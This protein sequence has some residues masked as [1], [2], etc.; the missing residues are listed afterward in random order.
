MSSQIPESL[1]RWVDDIVLEKNP[2]VDTNY[3]TDLPTHHRI[4]S[5]EVDEP[6]YK[7]VQEAKR[8]ARAGADSAK[9]TSAPPPPPLPGSLSE[10]EKKKRKTSESNSIAG[11]SG[12]DGPKFIRKHIFPHSQIAMDDASLCN[13]L[14]VLVWPGVRS[15]GGRL[16]LYQE[17]E[18]RFQEEVA[19]M[20]EELTRLQEREKK[21]MGQCAMAK[22]LKEKAEQNYVMLF[23]D[24]I[25]LQKQIELNREAYQDLEDPIAESSEETWR[26]FKEH[27][28]VIAPGL[29]LSLLHPDKIV[30]DG[31]IVSPPRPESDSEL[32]TRKQRLIE[33]PP[34]GEQQE[35]YLP[36]SSEAPTSVSEETAPTLL[37]P[38]ADPSSLPVGD[39]NPSN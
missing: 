22:G 19:W 20:K 35:G 39:S 23:A 34:R 24:N 11:E 14:Q 18:K 38:A 33:S 17:E 28:G 2:L 30:I 29:D 37:T 4:C 5:N 32:K 8:K 31:A 3:I 10:P 36:S 27:V 6:K 9:A 26:I 13:H 7:L 12:F 25:D 1:S 16:V 21:L 15:A